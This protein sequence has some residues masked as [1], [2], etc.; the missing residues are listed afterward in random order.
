MKKIITVAVLLLALCQS[1][2]L[3]AQD[4][5]RGA[6]LSG[7]RVDYISDSDI[8]KLKIQLQANNLT[9]DQAEL[10]AL[11]KGMSANEFAKLK[12]RVET[13]PT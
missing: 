6:D 5:F 12:F 9:I 10:M 1:S 3:L 8:S 13:V 2:T 11:S 7:I 4:L